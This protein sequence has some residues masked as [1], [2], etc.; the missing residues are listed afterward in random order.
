MASEPLPSEQPPTLAVPRPRRV[1]CPPTR[2]RWPGPGS[3]ISGD[4]AIFKLDG[5]DDDQLRWKPAPTAN[6]LG[7][8]VVHL[9][10]AERLWSGD[11]RR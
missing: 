8:I 3:S 11:L 4:S 6:S 10:Y 7:A 9:G 5:L 1:R 2:W